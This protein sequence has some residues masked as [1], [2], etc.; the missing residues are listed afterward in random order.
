M[1]KMPITVDDVRNL[2]IEAIAAE[3][4]IP[5]TEVATD[6]PFTAYG[7]DSMAVMSVGVEI[8]DMCGLSNLPPSLL[9]DYPTV[10]ALTES[11]WAM[12]TVSPMNIAPVLALAEDR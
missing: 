10:D 1:T 4:L 7:L 8:E 3:A 12:M 6:R 11:L 9:W 2:L 5:P